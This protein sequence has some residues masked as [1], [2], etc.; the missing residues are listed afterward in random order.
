MVPMKCLRV[1]RLNSTNGHSAILSPDKINL[2]PEAL[3]SDAMEK[4]AV[5]VDSEGLPSD[6][7]AGAALRVMVSGDLRKSMIVRALAHIAKTN[8]SSHFDSGQRPKPGAIREIVQFDVYEPERDQ[9]WSLLKSSSE[10]EE[11]FAYHS[12]TEAA[13]EVL[14][15]G[16]RK[17]LE[18][19][20]N[21]YGIKFDTRLKNSTIAEA[22]QSIIAAL[23]D[24]A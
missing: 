21:D 23:N 15:A 24:K 11:G 3:V 6:E 19:L 5:P 1:I 17:E 22:K 18:K 16:T 10:S 4:G 14:D 8:V 12:K 2:V 9:L 20:A 13:F 7:A